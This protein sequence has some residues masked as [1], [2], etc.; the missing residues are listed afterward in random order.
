MRILEVL[1]VISTLVLIFFLIFFK[2]LSHQKILVLSC[3]DM[4]V[5]LIHLFIEG[6]RWQLIPVYSVSVGLF[7]F[8]VGSSFITKKHAGI[9]VSNIY[10]NILFIFLIIF[11]FLS[12]SLALGLPIF[13]TPT[14]TGSLQVGTQILHFV[15]INRSETFTKDPKDKRELM[16][17]VWYPA[18]NIKDKKTL[19][20]MPDGNIFFTE[21]LNE[22]IKSEGISKF[23]CDYIKYV[24]SHSYENAEVSDFSA[25]YPMVLLNHGYGMSRLMYTCQ[26]ESLASNGYIV[27]GID[28]TYYSAA[29]KFSDGRVARLDM[30]TFSKDRKESYDNLSNVWGLFERDVT[31]VIDQL[32]KINNGEIKNVLNGK[33]DFDNIGAMGHSLGGA[34]TFDACYSDSRIK[35]GI[36]KKCLQ[37]C[38]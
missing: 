11:I 25:S 24:K 32:Y 36:C 33:I 38:I 13:K 8:N 6:Y 12:V 28:N 10:E 34:I 26:A 35:A 17:Q 22:D 3:S 2:R 14:P 15:D 18:Q 19:A 27:V 1:V 16:V 29:T 4:L 31:F 7:I 23:I 9:K 5:L 37:T 20:L 30:N 21:S